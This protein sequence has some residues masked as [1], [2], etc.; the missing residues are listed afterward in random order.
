MTVQ[1]ERAE[2]LV[3]H[4]PSLL[5]HRCQA[6]REENFFLQAESAHFLIFR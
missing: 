2:K 3:V 6:L 4:L 1:A 5:R